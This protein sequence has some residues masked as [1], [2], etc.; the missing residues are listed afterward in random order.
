MNMPRESRLGMPEPMTDEQSEA[1]SWLV[2]SRGHLRGPL[3]LWLNSPQ[4]ALAAAALGDVL[5]FRSDIREDLKEIAIL[6]TAV[7]WRAVHP[8]QAHIPLA[9]MAGVPSVAI[10]E[11]LREQAPNLDRTQT[12]VYDFVRALLKHGEVDDESYARI[13]SELGDA[14]MVELVALVGYYSLVSLSLNA[15]K[16]P[17]T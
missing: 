12:A 9:L 13:A 16:S 3:A 10:D 17:A 5:R 8:R 4:L 6:V 15:F 1:A 2:K 14:Q 7:H 11:I